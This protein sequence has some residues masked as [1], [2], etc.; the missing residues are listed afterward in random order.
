VDEKLKKIRD[1]NRFHK[2]GGMELVKELILKLPDPEKEKHKNGYKKSFVL[3]KA[4]KIAKQKMGPHRKK[5]HHN[6]LAETIL[7]YAVG[8]G[9]LR[10]VEKNKNRYILTRK[11]RK[12][13]EQEK[14]KNSTSEAQNS[15]APS[16]KEEKI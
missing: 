15:T 4:V 8:N 13:R 2:Y 12:L 6:F 1:R 11:S 3:S 10:P 14:Q 7:R 16:S 5:K 9:Y